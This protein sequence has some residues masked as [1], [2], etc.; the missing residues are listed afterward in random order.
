MHRNLNEDLA[1][2]LQQSICCFTDLYCNGTQLKITSYGQPAPYSHCGTARWP[3]I[4]A[5]W[6]RVTALGPHDLPPCCHAS[7]AAVRCL[8]LKEEPGQLFA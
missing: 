5:T 6:Q 3:L 1:R 4:T 2:A 7:F 8:L